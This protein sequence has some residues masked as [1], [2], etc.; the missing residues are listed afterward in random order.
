MEDYQGEKN[1]KTAIVCILIAAAV[2]TAAKLL[3]QRFQESVCLAVS[4]TF[5]N[6]HDNACDDDC[7]HRGLPGEEPLIM[8]WRT[9][10]QTL[11]QRSGSWN[12]LL[13]AV[14]AEAF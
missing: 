7:D 11:S 6:P 3:V 4:G 10:S 9:D 12:V 1:I 8:H 2:V 5:G 14:D 13:D